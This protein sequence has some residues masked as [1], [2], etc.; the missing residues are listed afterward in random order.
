MN[1]YFT[2]I[3][4]IDDKF[5][6]SV[7]DANTNQIIFR[8]TGAHSTPSDAIVEVNN[9]LQLQSPNTIT[10]DSLQMPVTQQQQQE[11]SAPVQNNVQV[12]PPRRCCGR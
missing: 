12:E 3:E 2:S 4:N 7:H 10:G 1:N 11:A 6:G 5:I 9:F 8:T